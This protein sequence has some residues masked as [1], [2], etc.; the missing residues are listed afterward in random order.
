[1]Q[2]HYDATSGAGET[3]QVRQ[4]RMVLAAWVSNENEEACKA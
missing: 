4:L 3:G 1:M 2:D